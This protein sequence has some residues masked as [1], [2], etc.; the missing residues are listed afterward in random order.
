MLNRTLHLSVFKSICQPL[1]HP[2]SLWLS[3]CS[4]NVLW[5]LYC[6]IKFCCLQTSKFYSA[7][8]SNQNTVHL[9]QLFAAYQTTSFH[10]IAKHYPQSHVLVILKL[11][12]YEKLY[13]M[14]FGNLNTVNKFNS[15]STI[16]I[17]SDFFHENQ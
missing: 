6:M 10:S 14:L 8:T 17:V 3:G 15:K 2:T 5:R 16:Q 11:I 9:I 13:R 7:P 4:H 12:L 1:D